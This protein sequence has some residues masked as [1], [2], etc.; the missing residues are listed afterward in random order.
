MGDLFWFAYMPFLFFDKRFHKK[1]FAKYFKFFRV[2][3][4]TNTVWLKIL[5]ISI[6]SLYLSHKIM[7]P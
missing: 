6:D 7:Y 1:I 2:D 3:K 4:N 5:D